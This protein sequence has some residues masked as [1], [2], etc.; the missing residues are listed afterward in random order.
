M[1]QNS[2]TNIFVQ[3]SKT[4][5]LIKLENLILR[6]LKNSSFENVQIKNSNSG[7]T[8]RLKTFSLIEQ[9]KNYSDKTK[10]INSWKYKNIKN[11]KCDKT[12]Q[13]KLWQLK[14]LQNLKLQI[15]QLKNSIVTK[16]ITDKIN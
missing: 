10:K 16:L 15:L 6:K 9:K 1:R 2:K 8:Q 3:I 11:Q 5:V 4:L 13:P 12:Q 14:L 7:K